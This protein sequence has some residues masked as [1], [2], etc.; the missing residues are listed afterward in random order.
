LPSDTVQVRVRD[1][2]CEK[3]A[4]THSLGPKPTPRMGMLCHRT[5]LV[6]VNSPSSVTA[7]GR[8]QADHSVHAE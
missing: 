3:K 4:S 8:T 5:H 2:R 1:L 6:P 7:Q